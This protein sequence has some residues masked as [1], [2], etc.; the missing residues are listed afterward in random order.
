MRVVLWLQERCEGDDDHRANLGRLNWRGY[1][2]P[3]GADYADRLKNQVQLSMLV[4][5]FGYLPKLGSS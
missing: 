3:R 4:W 1:R 2:T 5:L